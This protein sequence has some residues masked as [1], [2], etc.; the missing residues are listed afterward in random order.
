MRSFLPIIGHDACAENVRKMAETE[1]LKVCCEEY[2]GRFGIVYEYLMDFSS[3]KY[4]G[5][6]NETTDS[7]N[8]VW[9]VSETELLIVS[10]PNQLSRVVNI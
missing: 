8:L 7:F 10:R 2:N 3:D 4:S 1:E 5:I 6:P 9:K